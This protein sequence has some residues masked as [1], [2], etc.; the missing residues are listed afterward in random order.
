MS[1]IRIEAYSMTAEANKAQNLA[2]FLSFME[3][4]A[5]RGTKLVLFPELSLTGL[6]EG[7]S[8]AWPRPEFSVYFHGNAEPV[9]EGP[10]VQKLIEK[11]KELELY[12]CW[13]M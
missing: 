13:S 7:L 9:P 12:A 2:Q 5:A 3:E 4:S 1:Q 11:A 6:P 8:M 10:S